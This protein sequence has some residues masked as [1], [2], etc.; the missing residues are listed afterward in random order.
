MIAGRT[1]LLQTVMPRDV[2]VSKVLDRGFP[3]TYVEV[4]SGAFV[5]QAEFARLITVGSRQ[6]CSIAEQFGHQCLVSAFFRIPKLHCNLP[7][8]IPRLATSASAIVL[9]RRRLGFDR[10]NLT[11]D[12]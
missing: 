11:P 7:Q 2:P 8:L 1:P 3:N 12:V 10:Q 9:H 6:L 4:F 5:G